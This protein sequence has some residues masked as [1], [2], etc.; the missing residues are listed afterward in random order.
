MDALKLYS[1]GMK[2]VIALMG[3]ALTSNQVEAIKKLQ[4]E[5]I[6]PICIRNEREIERSY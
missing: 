1:A 3:T 2:N 4:E 6:N 5:G